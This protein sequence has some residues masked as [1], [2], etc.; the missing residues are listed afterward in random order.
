[1]LEMLLVIAVPAA[2]GTDAFTMLRVD[3]AQ[4][5][6]LGY[7]LVQAWYACR[8]KNGCGE[9]LC[10]FALALCALVLIKMSGMAW[11][12]MAIA[13]V[14]VARSLSQNSIRLRPVMVAAAAPV[15]I[16]LSWLAF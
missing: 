16:L 10:Y 6:C 8:E 9:R 4:G 15:M 14:L 1:M 2:L 5:L 12:L 3:S 7:A 11:V 13:F